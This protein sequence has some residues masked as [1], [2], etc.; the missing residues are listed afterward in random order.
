[1]AVEA[2][3]TLFKRKFVL[4]DPHVWFQEQHFHSLRSLHDR[5]R[6]SNWYRHPQSTFEHSAEPQASPRNE[7]DQGSTGQK[8]RA[9]QSNELDQTVIMS[10]A[11]TECSFYYD[12]ILIRESR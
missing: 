11:K 9:D 5:S 7:K 3:A 4:E 6:A 8:V 2:L 1:M 12:C 10:K